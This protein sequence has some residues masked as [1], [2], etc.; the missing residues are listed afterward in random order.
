MGAWCCSFFSSEIKQEMSTPAPVPSSSSSN[1]NS[2][3]ISPLFLYLL[4]LTL[5]SAI[6]VP[7]AFYLIFDSLTIAILTFI[8]YFIA[9]V[10][11]LGLRRVLDLL[12]RPRYEMLSARRRDEVDLVR[13]RGL[14]RLLG[15]FTLVSSTC[16]SLSNLWVRDRGEC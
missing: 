15:R 14:K 4:T 12:F 6:V 7:A 10:C 3:N 16:I 11:A 2:M 1:R 13:E 9:L 8:L 5:V